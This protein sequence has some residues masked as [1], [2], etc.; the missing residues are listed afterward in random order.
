MITA[1]E[2]GHIS[3][4]PAATGAPRVGIPQVLHGLVTVE[5]HEVAPVAVVPGQMYG[6]AGVVIGA[7]DTC[8]QLWQ[9]RTLVDVV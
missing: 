2:A 4:A 5:M 7:S 6:V 8:S 3:A 1:A 9:P